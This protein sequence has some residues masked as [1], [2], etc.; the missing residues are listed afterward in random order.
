M[1]SEKP[2]VCIHHGEFI[3]HADECGVLFW[4]SPEKRLEAIQTE[5]KW[6]VLARERKR[7]KEERTKRAKAG[8]M[9]SL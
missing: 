6:R 3:W 9:P 4:G 2:S 1:H 7:T 5:R 8:P